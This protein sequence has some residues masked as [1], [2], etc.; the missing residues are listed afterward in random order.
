MDIE[1]LLTEISADAPCGPDLSYDKDFFELEQ[2]LRGKAEQQFGDTVIAGEG[3]DWGSALRLA[4]ELM[5]R[6]KDLRVAVAFLRAQVC[7]HQL[8]GLRDGVMVLEQLFERYWATL[9]PLLDADDNDDPTERVN[10]MA[11][12]IE[13]TG[14]LRDV[15][16]ALVVNLPGVG[17][18]TIRDILVM[19]GKYPANEG[20]TPQTQNVIEAAMRAALHQSP[21]EAAAVREAYQSL[22]RVHRFLN[23]KLGAD[24]APDMRPLLDLVKA[25]MQLFDA[26]SPAPEAAVEGGEA[27]DQAGEAV[28]GGPSVVAA[29][30]VG[31]LRSREDAIRALDKVCEFMER[32]EPG[33]PAPLLVRR[34]QRLMKMSFFEIIEDLTPDSL[35]KIKGIA[36]I[37]E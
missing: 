22:L 35:A 26:L 9:H 11:P 20:E 14:F 23:D 27:A 34:A 24:T 29:R 30:A 21:G 12:L 33:H 25:P 8:A 28:A 4:T 36:G 10:A 19:Q 16:Q 6:T 32:N 5:G 17:N 1:A 15:R 37:S 13:S 7:T 3:P 31:E 18:I 2:A